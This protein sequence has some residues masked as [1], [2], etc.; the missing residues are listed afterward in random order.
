MTPVN[1]LDSYSPNLLLAFFI[2]GLATILLK[3]LP[4]T[5]LKED[6]IPSL[7]RRWLDFVP[8]AVMA[9]LVG[10]DIF[11]YNG[12]LDFGWSNLFLMVSIP[13]IVVAWISKNYFVTIAFGLALI[14]GARF[15]GL[16]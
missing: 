14:L 6:A 13:T 5:F 11:I 7:V 15:M 4:I 2:A 8:V 3:T 12:K 10:P 9:A 16:N 1:A